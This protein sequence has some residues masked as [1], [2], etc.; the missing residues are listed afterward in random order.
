[1]NDSPVP[2]GT[3]DHDVLIELRSDVK[4]LNANVT[5]Y[6]STSS[7]TLTD[8]E[9]RLTVLEKDAEVNKGK[10]ESRTNTWRTLLEVVG[11]LAAVISAYGAYLLG[12]Q[13]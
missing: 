6:I 7:Q 3:S 4:N 13:R 11:V 12:H 2:A 5:Q 9:H 10:T 8:H 1:M